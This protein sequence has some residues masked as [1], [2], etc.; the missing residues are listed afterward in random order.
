MLTIEL[1]KFAEFSPIEMLNFCETRRRIK[2]IDDEEQEIITD[3]RLLSVNW[4]GLGLHR[5]CKEE[6]YRINEVITLNGDH[7]YPRSFNDKLA[8]KPIDEFL[9]VVLSK[10]DDPVFYDLVKQHIFV[11]QNLLHNF[12]SILGERGVVSARSSDVA[13]IFYHPKIKKIREDRRSNKISTQDAEKVFDQILRTESDFDKTIFALLYRTGGVD[14]IQSYQLLIERGMVFDLNN[15]IMPFNVSNSYSEGIINL[16]DSLA[17][18]KGAGFSLIS[19]GSALQ[20]SE[21][22]HKK[23]HNLA[24]GVIGIQYRFDC[25]STQ[26]PIVKVISRDFAN[27]LDGKWLINEDGST[28]LIDRR[29]PNQLVIGERYKIRSVAWCNVS[30]NGKPCSKCFGKMETALPYNPYT[31]KGAV[32]GLFY[33]SVFGERIGQSILKSKHRIGSAMSVPFV[34]HPE[35]EDYINTDGDLIFFNES[36]LN[37][38]HNPMLILDKETGL[39]F[40]DY[41]LMDDIDELDR[42]HLR[43]Y[44]DV[45]IKIAIPNPM[46]EGLYGLTYHNLITSVESRKGRMTKDFIQFIVDQEMVEDGKVHAVSLKGWDHRKPVYE[47]PFVNEDLDTYR[48]KVEEFLKFP[49]LKGRFNYLID[50]E[51]HGEYIVDFWKVVNERYDGANII[52]HDIFLWACMCRDPTNLDYSMPTGYDQRTF[53]SFHDCIL[54]RGQGNGTQYGWQAKGLM[55]SPLNFLTKFRQGGV[56]ESFLHPI[57]RM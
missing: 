23:I 28:T 1:R 19:N 34:V 30:H 3:T 10:S 26:G 54:N 33:G 2:V 25:Q 57:A 32:P 47:L 31:F 15:N 42:N 55:G 12:L 36:I 45:K 18:S 5:H 41:K 35:D 49:S 29:I 53:V 8:N 56:L 14:R 48:R 17:D 52:I 9:P 16:A 27:S 51:L 6:P 11:Y 13:E 46:V 38:K 22:F 37:D 40:S 50:P 7:G 24:H 21:W 4:F 39:D 43:T 20:D 44:E